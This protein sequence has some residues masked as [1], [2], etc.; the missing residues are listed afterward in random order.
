MIRWVPRTRFELVH[1]YECHPLKMVRLPISPP[2]PF[3]VVSCRLCVVGCDLLHVVCCRL[4]VVN[5]IFPSTYNF[6]SPATF[7]IQLATLKTACP[8]RDSNSQET[9]L[10]GFWDRNVYQFRHPG[11][12]CV[13]SCRHVISIRKPTPATFNTQLSTKQ[14]LQI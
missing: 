4:Q 3:F 1:P 2:G 6:K 10:N 8:K 7:N 13:V 12:F 5:F 9:I 11:L 14:A